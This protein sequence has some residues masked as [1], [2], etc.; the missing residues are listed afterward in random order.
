M[1]ATT[2]P[3]CGA[4]EHCRGDGVTV[5]KCGSGSDGMR[6]WNCERWIALR[7]SQ[8]RRMVYAT[9]HVEERVLRNARRFSTAERRYSAREREICGRLDRFRNAC[10]RELDRLRGQG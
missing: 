4:P 10:R 9:L 3:H 2:C 5:W 7:A 8:L 1:T 6:G